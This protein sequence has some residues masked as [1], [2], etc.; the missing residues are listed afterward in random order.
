[1]TK[2]EKQKEAIREAVFHALAGVWPRVMAGEDFFNGAPQ[3]GE[4]E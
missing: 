3:E 4:E 2:L 1:M